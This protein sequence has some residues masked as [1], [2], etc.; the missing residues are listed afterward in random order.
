MEEEV[1]AYFL[2]EAGHN[3]ELII[4][5]M[6][7]YTYQFQVVHVFVYRWMIDNMNYCYMAYCFES[8][9]FYYI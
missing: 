9:E 6:I 8:T 1:I 2:S 5:Y 7:N 3:I 4:Q